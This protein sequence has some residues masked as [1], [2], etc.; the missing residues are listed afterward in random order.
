[1]SFFFSMFSFTLISESSL[2]LLTEI[3]LCDIMGVVLAIWLQ[4]ITQGNAGRDQ[5]VLPKY[6]ENG[7]LEDPAQ[8][9]ADS[10][11]NDSDFEVDAEA[12]AK[13]EEFEEMDSDSGNEDSEVRGSLLQLEYF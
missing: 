4:G 8:D 12:V 11:N 7:E 3:C 1:M 10:C 5:L 13:E 6:D 2:V 9:E